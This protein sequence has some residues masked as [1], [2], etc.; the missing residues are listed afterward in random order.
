MINR[1]LEIDLTNQDF[2]ELEVKENELRKYL[3]G[4]GIA[5]RYL[6]QHLDPAIPPLHPDN[7]ILFFPGLLTG[8]PIPTASKTS[9]CGR[10]PLTGIW[11][12]ATVGGHWGAA[13]KKN[14]YEGIIIKGKS[15]HPIYLLINSKEVI[16]KDAYKLWGLDTY[17]TSK[18][19]KEA[20][21]Q[22]Q[23]AS[24][25][26][27][28]E[29]LVPISAIVIDAPH[30]RLAGRGGMGALMGSKNL[31]AIVV[32]IEKKTL[33]I[34][35]PE[36][37][38]KSVQELTPSIKLYTQ[39]LHEFGTGGSVE[40]RE[41]TGDLPIKNFAQSRWDGAA[42][43][44]GQVIVNTIFRKNYACY[45]C[46]I[47]C[48][49]EVF[50]KEEI[51]H[52]PEY[53]TL[54]AFGSNLLNDDLDSIV[55]MND[56]CN[57]Y[58]IDTISLGVILGF[59]IEAY[60]EGLIKKADLDGINLK[61]G[62]S[63]A[64]ITLIHQV[65]YKEKFGKF[66]GKGV[67]SLSNQLGGKSS[68]YAL[69]TKGLE[70]PMHDP[71]AYTGMALSYATANRGAC[72]LESLSYMIE[73][74]IP[75]PEFGYDDLHKP[76]PHSSDGKTELVVKLQDYMNVLNALGLCKF[77]LSGRIGPTIVSEWINKVT[78]W[79]LNQTELMQIG[80]RLHNLKR[81]YNVKLGITRQDDTLPPRLLNLARTDGLAAGVLPDID[82]MLSEYYQIRGWDDK[83]IPKKEKIKELEIFFT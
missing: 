32:Q 35:D 56:L 13:L 66:L 1:L 16:F 63:D 21:P 73:S 70:Y 6:Y 46:P 49:K 50:L 69:H 62:N 27:A 55:K 52:G 33:P 51:V 39:G 71:R 4:S 20:Y 17:E 31:K 79:D 9:I 28:G 10:S 11:N 2:H 3:G 59:A 54:S 38:K 44:T 80:Q 74:G 68:E 53:E 15:S 24:I 43:T 8:F 81:L 77:L 5:V 42:K 36:S 58:G 7:P 76:N 22:V 72:H 25:G 26:Q 67:K 78:G 60:E 34:T 83:G 82:S 30:C 37:L 14:G 64:F 65:A 57:R 75:A 45:F 48:G 47:A 19:I 61:W 23:I 40:A 29:N 41:Y 18:K 12:E